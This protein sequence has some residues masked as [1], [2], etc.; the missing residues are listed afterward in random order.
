M[1]RAIVVASLGAGAVVF[2]A[3]ARELEI[4]V[5]DIKTPAFSAEGVHAR[6]TGPRL[7]V[8]SLQV[9]RL[10]VAGRA[11]AKVRIDCSD[12][13]VSPARV[14]C[15]AGE[16]V[17]GARIPIRFVYSPATRTLELESKLANDETWQIRGQFG[18]S[19]AIDVALTNAAI[20]RI[21]SW[22]PASGS[23]VTQGRLG[24]SINYRDGRISAALDVS[25]LAFSDKSGLHAGDK[26][27]GRVIAEATQERDTWRWK[28]NTTWKAGE[29]FWQPFYVTA[30]SQRVEAE[31]TTSGSVTEIA[32]GRLDLAQIGTLSFTGRY[33]HGTGKLLAL[34][35]RSPRV[36]LGALYEQIL[37]PLAQG[38]ALAELRAEGEAGIAVEADASGIAALDLDLRNV[39]FEDQRRRFGVFGVTGRVPWKRTAW[40]DGELSIKGAELFTMPLG[41]VRVPLKLRGLRVDIEALNVP[42]LD[43][44]VSVRGFSAAQGQSGW[45]WRLA[46]EVQPISMERL[47]QALGLPVM[48]GLLAGVIPEVRYRREVLSM[49]GELAMRVFDGTVRAGKVELIEPFGR[50]PRL[51]AELAV[52][53]LDLELL[54]RTFDFGTITGRIDAD[55][56]NLELVAWQPVRFDASIASSPGSYPRRIS[57]RAVENISALGGAGAAAAIQRSFLRFFKDFSYDRIGVSCKLADG[58]CEMDGVER[59]P[60]GYVIVK[61]G[62][63]PSLSVI[64]YNR[65]V[66][67]RELVDRLKRVTRENVTPV[68]K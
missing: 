22:L 61:G 4:S 11:F 68:V 50:A 55:V 12:A 58:V 8:L 39:S 59:A 44:A 60:Q 38:G 28:A 14:A 66:N 57:Q 21:A 36:A 3:Q 53:S 43:G 42:L 64:G 5:A 2:I 46:G 49:D 51:Q 62:G 1:R 20:G 13:Q 9:D 40:T 63:V 48:H 32:R 65:S 24:G 35:A 37:K 29:A 10:T 19:V 33:D 7:S 18:R 15:P 16:A 54:T 67:W 23:A 6:M 25:G 27:A 52:R 34:E 41:A 17:V 45:R 56:K 47:T 26:I 30:R 31:G